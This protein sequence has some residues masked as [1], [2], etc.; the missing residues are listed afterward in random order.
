MLSSPEAG[1]QRHAFNGVSRFAVYHPGPTDHGGATAIEML[2]K[3]KPWQDKF[4]SYA[5]KQDTRKLD[6]CFTPWSW[7]TGL[8]LATSTLA[9]WRS[10]QMSYARG[11]RVFYQRN[12]R[13]SRLFC[14]IFRI[15]FQQPRR[16]RP[17]Q[18]RSAPPDP[19]G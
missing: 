18:T 6:V 4:A 8:E 1:S 5:Q 2:P 12:T 11:T 3:T 7:A 14:K 19:S 15:F 17:S 16:L 13:L 9:R 10:N